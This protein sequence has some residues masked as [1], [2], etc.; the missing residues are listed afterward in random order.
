MSTTPKNTTKL[1]PNRILYDDEITAWC[2]KNVPGWHGIYSRTDI[3]RVLPA[4]EPGAGVI[5]NLDPK[6]SQG[7]THWV[8][9]RVS[10]YAPLVYY[11]DSF[12]APP[13]ND[14]VA[15]TRASGLGLIYGNRIN[16]KIK[17]VNCGKRA[18]E[19]LAN[20]DAAG[21][22]EMYYFESTECS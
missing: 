10:K 3:G 14:V 19:W 6:Y 9:L 16:Q 5:L 21:P 17:E 7:G 20:M 11:K 12:G 8:A 22:A 1:L 2:K 13:P 4:L 18:A 15:A